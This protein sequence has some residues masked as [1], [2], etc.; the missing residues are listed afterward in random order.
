MFVAV[1]HNDEDEEAFVK[2]QKGN[3]GPRKEGTNEGT[4]RERRIRN[5]RDMLLNISELDR[6]L[7]LRGTNGSNIGIIYLYIH[8]FYIYVTS[9]VTTY[10]AVTRSVWFQ[11]FFLL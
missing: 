6:V 3:G 10:V 2:A 1:A 8:I 9:H 5:G 4:K 7:H 11:K